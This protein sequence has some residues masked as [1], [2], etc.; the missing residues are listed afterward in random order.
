MA[1][2]KLAKIA[3]EKKLF[4]L[5]EANAT[6]PLVRAVVGDIAQLANELRERHARLVRMQ[7]PERGALSAAHR[8]ELLQAEDDFKRQEERL[9]EYAEELKS[10]GVELKDYY[11]G[12]IDFPCWHE[13]RVVYLCWRLG[14]PEIAHWHELEA[15][16][17]GRQ[18]IT[19][20][21]MKG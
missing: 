6:L 19:P 12:L 9:L 7:A 18:S 3:R 10:L 1:A 5:A 17:P 4:T 15:G 11:T 2:R 21:M 20:R 16:F 14:E 13:N 8:E